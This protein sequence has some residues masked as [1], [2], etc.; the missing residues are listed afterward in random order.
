[1]AAVQPCVGSSKYDIGD[2]SNA[3]PS[4]MA[5]YR[6]ETYRQATNM[7]VASAVNRTKCWLRIDD[8]S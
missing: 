7:T 3:E 8:D 5:S 2:K 4:A 6:P 1:M